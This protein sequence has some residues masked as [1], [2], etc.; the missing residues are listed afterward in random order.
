MLGTGFRCALE[1]GANKTR[2]SVTKPSLGAKHELSGTLANPVTLSLSR[3]PSQ[4]IYAQG[5][6]ATTI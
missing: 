6:I 1:V 5:V 3:G 4:A 2:A